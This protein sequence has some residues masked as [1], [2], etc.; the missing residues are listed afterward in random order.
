M[1]PTI[2]ERDIELVIVANRVAIPAE[3]PSRILIIPG[4]EVET[5]RGPFTMDR[6]AADRIIAAFTA[7]G[8]DVPID[9]EHATIGR[10]FAPPDGSA[11]AMAWIKSMEFVEGEGLYANVEWTPKGEDHVKNREY[12]YLSPTIQHR[13]SDNA[14]M[15]LHSVALTNKPAIV[16]MKPIANK[17]DVM[18]FN[19]DLLERSRWFLNLPTTATETEIMEHFEKLLL[20]L[21]E[22]AG[23]SAN[24]DQQGTL[25]ALKEKLKGPAPS[26]LR[27]ELCKTL[28][29]KDDVTDDAIVKACSDAVA[30]AQAPDPAKYVPSSAVRELTSELTALKEDRLKEKTALFL[31]RGDDAGKI[32][33]GNKGMWER[34]YKA[35]PEQAE[36]DLA[37]APVIAPPSGRRVTPAQTT[38]GVAGVASDTIVANSEQ[39]EGERMGDYQKIAKYA[40]DKNVSFE[41]AME[42]CGAL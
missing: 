35:D 39:F 1:K 13:K 9:R 30:N 42:A 19:E 4:G 40:A 34:S 7:H 16:G 14:V 22:L 15:V 29:L 28:A 31:K 41:K 12:R 6:A 8:V 5:K 10:E 37:V 27:P 32:V 21:R 26:T 20:Q 18:T 11:P 3:A 33:E 17:E 38:T 23:V 2:I 24:T 36:K 25:A